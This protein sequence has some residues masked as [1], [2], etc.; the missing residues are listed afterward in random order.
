M[1]APAGAGRVQQPIAARDIDEFSTRIVQVIG[2][3]L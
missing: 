2:N 3:P 1:N